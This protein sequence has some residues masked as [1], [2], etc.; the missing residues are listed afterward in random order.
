MALFD[1]RVQARQEQSA[2]RVKESQ[3]S[4]VVGADAAAAAEDEL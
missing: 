1:A 3:D 4:N 2:S